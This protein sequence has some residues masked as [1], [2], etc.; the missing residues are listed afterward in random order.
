MLIKCLHGYFIFKESMAG[1]LS[2]FMAIFSDLSI[3]PVE[4][5]FTFEF[6]AEAPSHVIAGSTYL[7]APCLVSVEGKPW[8]IMRANSLIYDF[9]NDV[10]IPIAAVLSRLE[11]AESSNYFVSPGLIMPGSI[12]NQG[13]RVKE[14]SAWM[15][16][17]SQSFKYT[18]VG[19][20]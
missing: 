18:E 9:A 2:R 8:D 7:G 16:F 4:D 3:V 6:L 17:E 13:Q 11:I 15:N 1:D 12:N 20:E 19:Y 14:Y 10:V 5:Y